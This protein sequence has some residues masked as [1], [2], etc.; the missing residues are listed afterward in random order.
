[1]ADQ[2]VGRGGREPQEPNGDG[3]H[4][5]A[6]ELLAG[7]GVVSHPRHRDPSQRGIRRLGERGI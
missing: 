4:L 7:D 1:M 3:E 6:E 2:E 5:G